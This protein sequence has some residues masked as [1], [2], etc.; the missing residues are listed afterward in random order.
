M[1]WACF[2]PNLRLGT[3]PPSYTSL[4]KSEIKAFW[5]AL[6]L[7]IVDGRVQQQ[8]VIKTF[9]AGGYLKE[10]PLLHTKEKKSTPH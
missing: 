10:P 3:T 8:H 9:G 7:S 2:A 1:E 6:G 5:L 4:M